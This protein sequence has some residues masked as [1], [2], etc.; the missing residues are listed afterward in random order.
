MHQIEQ[1]LLLRKISLSTKLGSKHD[2]VADTM[3]PAMLQTRSLGTD[4]PGMLRTCF[5][6]LDRKGYL[7]EFCFHQ[8]K[9]FS[10]SGMY[11]RVR[12]SRMSLLT[13]SAIA[14]PDDSETM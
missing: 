6:T 9:G 8:R 13:L 14:T 11:G 5:A 2:L 7:V 12:Y 1:T 4:V 10:V 3:S